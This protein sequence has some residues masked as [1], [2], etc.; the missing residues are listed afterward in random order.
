[1]RLDDY[2]VPSRIRRAVKERDGNR[3]R[4]CGETDK[5]QRLHIDHIEPKAC[6]GALDD[7]SNLQ[8]LCAS[9]NFYKGKGSLC[10][11]DHQ[12]YLHPY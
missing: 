7:L 12:G 8:T 1:M 3:C 4:C 2:Q 5:Y 6:G 10:T 11:Y 9:C